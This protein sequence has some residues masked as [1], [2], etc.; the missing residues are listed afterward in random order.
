MLVKEHSIIQQHIILAVLNQ[1]R[2]LLKDF[3]F[4]ILTLASTSIY[5]SVYVYL[6]Q[7]PFLLTKLHFATGEFSLFF[8][9]ISI[10][11]ILG[12][13]I[14]KLMLR[15]GVKF[16]NRIILPICLFITSLTIVL[17]TKI[18]NLPLSGWLL[19][20]PFFIFT[21]GSG[22]GAPNISSEALSLHP[23]RRGT[24]ASALGLLQNLAAFA[25]S[26]LGA[27]LIKYGYDGLII[28]YIILAVLPTFWIIIYRLLI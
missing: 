21:I 4:I 24:A 27:F 6:S 10:A 3:K 9:P 2:H 11:F 8:I 25:F 1:Y 7:V 5:I 16:E 20:I 15:K 13:I 18:I 23:H 19:A 28:S 12:G 17:V 26:G 14:S 22:I